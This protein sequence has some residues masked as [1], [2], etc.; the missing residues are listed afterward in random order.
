MKIIIEV[1]P[2]VENPEEKTFNYLKEKLI[3]GFNEFSL[4]IEESKFKFSNMKEKKDGE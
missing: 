1:N 4:E 3:D 2:D